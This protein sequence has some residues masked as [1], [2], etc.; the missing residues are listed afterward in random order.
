MSQ[1]KFRV[2]EP[3]TGTVW[4]CTWVADDRGM[5]M[6]GPDPAFGARVSFWRCESNRGEVRTVTYV[7]EA[8]PSLD[9]QSAD[10]QLD[11]IR[12]SAALDG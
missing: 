8:P 11:R 1:T 9:H 3:H 5:A 6:S 2:A 12:K 7:D 4:T 10:V